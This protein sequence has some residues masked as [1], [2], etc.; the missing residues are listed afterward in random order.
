LHLDSTHR[1]IILKAM[2][3]RKVERVVDIQYIL[4]EELVQSKRVVRG[5]DK[6]KASEDWPMRYKNG[7]GLGRGADGFDPIQAQ[8]A[9]P[10]P[11]GTP[12]RAPGPWSMA[13]GHAFR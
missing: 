10:A 2:A 1:K 4:V 3:K 11:A 13:K 12:T 8:T 5:R 7:K 6:T 9:C